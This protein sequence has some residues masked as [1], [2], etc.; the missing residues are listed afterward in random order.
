M[1]KTFFIIIGTILAGI[2]LTALVLR[3]QVA[4]FVPEAL[5]TSWFRSPQKNKDVGGVKNSFHQIAWAVDVVPVDDFI[6]IKLAK[7]FPQVVIESDHI[8]AEFDFS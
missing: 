3:L 7:I 1:A 2:V 8:H 4:L 5:V 6:D